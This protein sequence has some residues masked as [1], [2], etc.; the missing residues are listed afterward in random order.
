MLKDFLK[1]WI[2][3][4]L[5]SVFW[6]IAVQVAWGM[7]LLLWIL[8]YVKLHAATAVPSRAA[9]WGGL[10][11][12]ALMIFGVNVLVI[13]YA[14]QA[15]H[16]RVVKDFVSRVSHD[17]RSPLSSVKLHLETLLKR[18]LGPEQT[19]SCLDAAWQDLGRLEASIEGIL[20]ASRLEHQKLQIELQTLDFGDFLGGYLARKREVVEGNGGHLQLGVLQDLL[21]RADPAMMEKILDNLLDNAL[22]HC[23][24]GVH[25]RVALARKNRLALLT[26]ADDG[27]GIAPGDRNKIFRLFYRAAASRG[28]GTGLGL[29]IA[30]SLVR[31]HGGRIWVECP[32]VGSMFQVALPLREEGG[33]RP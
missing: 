17:L 2:R 13:H 30:A 16:N 15:A 22:C 4:T 7:L 18:E 21:I 10:G 1:L 14:R 20:M 31:A 12:L 8:A 6:I 32:G 3:I 27:P 33:G 24:P 11:F 26:V 25:I 28:R 23:P 19:R 9:F 5:G 29:F